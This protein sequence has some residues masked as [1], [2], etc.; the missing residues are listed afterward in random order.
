MEPE[1]WQQRWRDNKIG[2]HLEDVN[3]YLLKHWQDLGLKPGSR[4]FVPLSGKSVDMHWLSEQG[5]QVEAVEVSEL[6]VKQFF[7][8]QGLTAE[9]HD[10]NGWIYYQAGSLRIWCG[11]F[12]KL[13]AEKLGPVDAIYDRA[14]L[15]ALPELMRPTYVS[16]LLEL[17]G[18]R[19]QLLI[20]LEYEQ[21]QMTGP[22]FS[23]SQHEVNQLYQPVYGKVVEPAEKI[24]VLPSHEHFAVRGLTSLVEC[25]YVLQVSKK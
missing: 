13:D 8:E 7:E 14:A 5:F 12:F 24:D 2:F 3:P 11:D 23:V 22:P 1:F 21:S 18:P 20:T 4:V 9:R 6:A 15:I 16:K 19:P 17:T 10:L 25:V